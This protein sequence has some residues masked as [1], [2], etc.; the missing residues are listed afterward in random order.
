[1]S[2]DLSDNIDLCSVCMDRM[3]TKRG[4]SH[5]IS[6]PMVKVEQTL[7]DFHFAR[8]VE[9]AKGALE[10]AKGV[11][12]N[13]EAALR[14]EDASSFAMTSPRSS[15]GL[16]KERAPMD[17]KDLIACAC[18]RRAV[19]TPC[20]VCVIC[21]ESANSASHPYIMTF[22]AP[23]RETFICNECDVNRLPALPNGPA[24]THKTSHPLI[25]LRDSSIA[26]QNASTEEKL[27]ALQQR[28]VNL[29]QKVADG[30]SMIDLKVEERM[31]RLEAKMESRFS[32]F[33]ATTEQRFD[34]L[35]ALLRQVAAQ[36]SALPALYGEV[37]REQVQQFT[38]QRRW[39]AP[40]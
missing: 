8:V 30:L 23:A 35:E 25:R 26:G 2:D 24:P 14:G 9:E 31:A 22:C 40:R 34:T 10:R 32:M 18:C 39:F 28:L 29:E 27:A 1:M 16:G 5:D 36:T 33:E 37:V 11:L 21:R 19:N 3:P 20:W 38:Q 15:R 4:F 6:H 12:R 13:V 17:P 7:H